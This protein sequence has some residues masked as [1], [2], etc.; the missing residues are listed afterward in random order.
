MLLDFIFM[1]RKFNYRSEAVVHST[2]GVH[3]VYGGFYQNRKRLYLEC[4]PLSV[5]NKWRSYTYRII[6]N[7]IHILIIYFLFV[8]S[9]IVIKSMVEQNVFYT[10]I[11]SHWNPHTISL[12][13]VLV[14]CWYHKT[15]LYRS[16]PVFWSYWCINQHA[17]CAD[18]ITNCSLSL[19][20]WHTGWRLKQKKPHTF[21][22]QN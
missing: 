20:F 16:C 2:I 3:S 18:G 5:C 7:Y 21:P 14:M 12:R 19:W 4:R 10:I 6:W 11:R 22:L 13:P 1:S 8:L 15:Q 9:E 17:V